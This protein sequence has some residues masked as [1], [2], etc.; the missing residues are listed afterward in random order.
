MLAATPTTVAVF[1]G[2]GVLRRLDVR[3]F[4]GVL[5]AVGLGTGD[6]EGTGVARADGLDT[7]FAR[8]DGFGTGVGVAGGVIIGAGLAV[9]VGSAAIGEDAE[10]GARGEPKK[11]ASA[12]PNSNPAKITTRTRG[13]SGSPPPASSDRRRRRGSLRTDSA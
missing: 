12:P 13:K 8:A 2:L 5:T 3:S 11:C 9:E 4:A 1:A 7:G 6:V 10:I